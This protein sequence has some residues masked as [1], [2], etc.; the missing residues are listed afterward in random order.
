MIHL[1]ET[2][3][4]FQSIGLPR[5]LP[6]IRMKHLLQILRRRRRRRLG[7][8]PG[9][10]KRKP[11][12]NRPLAQPPRDRRREPPAPAGKLFQALV[13]PSRLMPVI[14]REKLVRAL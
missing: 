14:A 10:F 4:P 2:F 3:K 9:V 1:L 13:D 7:P 11:L 5:T 12:E 8:I 6:K